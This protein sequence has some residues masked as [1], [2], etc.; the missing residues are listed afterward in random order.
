[1]SGRGN[2]PQGRRGRG[3]RGPTETLADYYRTVAADILELCGA[4]RSGL[5]VD[6]G[7]GEGG[8][9]LALARKSQAHLVLVDP[10]GQALARAV[11]AACGAGLHERVSAV[12]GRAEQIPLRSG[13]VRLV[14]SRGSIF[15]WDDPAEGL[16]EVY[17]VLGKGGQAVIGGGLGRRYPLWARTEFVRRRHQA[18]QAKGPAAVREF[19]RLRS[20]TTF[21]RW[22]EEAGLDEYLVTGEGGLP[23][24]HPDTGLGLWLRFAK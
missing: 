10:N 18:V 13:S 6:L 4:D 12:C 19:Q 14:V 5:W 16:R 17:R 21:R 2:R 8:V 22:A 15:F 23:P 9:G 24:E 20:P 3:E 7:S 1:M 11:E